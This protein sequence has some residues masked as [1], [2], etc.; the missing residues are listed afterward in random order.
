MKYMSSYST[1][2]KCTKFPVFLAGFPPQLKRDMDLLHQAQPRASKNIKGQEHLSYKENLRELW[3]FTVEKTRASGIL[4]MCTSISWEGS[5]ESTAKL[6]SLCPVT[7]QG[8]KLN[9]TKFLKKHTKILQRK[10]NK[11]K[12]PR[13]NLEDGWTLAQ[14]AE[15][16]CGVA[17]LRDIHNPMGQSLMTCSS[18]PCLSKR[19]DLAGLQKFP[20]TLTHSY[21]PKT[22]IIICVH[23]SLASIH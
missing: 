5:T 13:Q 21:F 16:G 19:I 23:F 8:H 18:C 1:S 11:Q 10:R 6:L 3:W 2:V 12:H 22:Q 4:P 17:I 14:V 20:L 9:P 15:R 7:A